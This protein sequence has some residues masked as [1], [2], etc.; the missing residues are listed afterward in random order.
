MTRYS[1]HPLILCVLCLS[2]IGLFYRL[3]TEPIVVMSEVLF[4]IA[5]VAIIFFL[6]KKFSAHK[7]GA[8]TKYSSPYQQAK[9]KNSR[10]TAESNVVPHKKKKDSKKVTRPLIKKRTEVNLTVIEG[11]KNK[12][13]NRALF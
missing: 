11:K 9:R 13:K 7:F 4:M 6:M 5:F 10:R 2:I 8:S 1:F 3:Y 12:K